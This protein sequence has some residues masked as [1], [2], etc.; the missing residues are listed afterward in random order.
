MDKSRW[1]L[2]L[3]RKWGNVQVVVGFDVL[4]IAVLPVC[5]LLLAFEL[6]INDEGPVPLVD[7]ISD[8][9]SQDTLVCRADEGPVLESLRQVAAA[10]LPGVLTLRDLS[11]ISGEFFGQ[12]DHMQVSFVL[13]GVNFKTNLKHSQFLC[14]H[15]WATSSTLGKQL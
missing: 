2:Q 12:Q 11:E 14:K 9:R 5:T 8:T 7:W 15:L 10:L 13:D 4:P 6:L 3:C 1:Q